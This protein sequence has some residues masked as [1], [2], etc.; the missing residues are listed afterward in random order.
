MWDYTEKVMD[1]FLHPRNVGEIKDADAVGE[2]G[3]LA[4]GDALKLYLKLGEGER[5]VDARF[6]TFGCASAIASAS[7]LTELV[8]GK[9]LEE[10]AKITNQDIARHLGGLPKEKM[11][12]SVMGREALEAAI[13]NY[14]TG[15]R[16]VKTHEE[17]VVCTCFGVTEEVIERAIRE[18]GLSTVDEVTNYTKAGGGCGG[19][20]ADIEAILAR[21]NGS[22]PS[23][24][25]PEPP[26]APRRLTNIQKI[27]LI[28]ETIEREVRPLLKRDGGDLELVD[29]S[30]DRVVV[31]FRGACH[32]CRVAG[33][34]LKDVVQPKLREFVSPDLVVVEETP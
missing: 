32:Q 25:K 11:H 7:A 33:V 30:G 21:V 12:C 29:V 3:N 34:T 5:I 8:R 20:H 9:T 10:A 28:E 31:A 1:H 27:R 4:C 18:N 13:E 26:P 17:R 15:A 14:R 23:A 6:Q 16:V 22:A 2:V 19:C 24:A